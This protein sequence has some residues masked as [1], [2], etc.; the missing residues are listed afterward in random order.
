MEGAYIDII[1]LSLFM[2]ESSLTKTIFLRHF[3][4]TK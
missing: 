4:V 2:S 1:L 3:T